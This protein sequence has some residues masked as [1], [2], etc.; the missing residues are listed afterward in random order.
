MKSDKLVDQLELYSNAIVGF[1]VAQSVAFSFTFGTSADF[2]CEITRYRLLSMGLAAHFVIATLLASWAVRYLCNQIVSLSNENGTVLRT[3]C[4]A[5]V[6]VC[7]LFAV[8]P[9]GLLL[10]FGVFGDPTKG[11]CAK[12][13]KVT[14][15]ALLQS[16]T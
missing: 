9:A 2:G 1:T 10:A 3:I 4:S 16:A 11:R 7:I 5:K 15:E 13:F 12:L 8:L 6:V 14:A